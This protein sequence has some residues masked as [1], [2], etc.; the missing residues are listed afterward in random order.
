MES[1]KGARQSQL[2]SNAAKTLKSAPKTSSTVNSAQR[3]QE[4][5][6]FKA[7]R[8]KNPNSENMIEWAKTNPNMKSNAARRVAK[9]RPVKIANSSANNRALANTQKRTKNK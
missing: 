4:V 6:T 3:A 5:A 1:K 7:N 2:T 9:A 8:P